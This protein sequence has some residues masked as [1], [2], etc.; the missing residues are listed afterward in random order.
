MIARNLPS[1]AAEIIS[2]PLIQYNQTQQSPFDLLRLALTAMER[3]KAIKRNQ[4]MTSYLGDEEDMIEVNF[5][6]ETLN[7]AAEIFYDCVERDPT[8]LDCMSWYVAVRTG[9]M[10]VGSGILI[11][12]GPCLAARPDYLLED[13]TNPDLRCRHSDYS[14]L[15]AACSEA[16]RELISWQ[17]RAPHPGQGYHYAIKSFLEWDEV[18]FLL[19][20]RP[21]INP[22]CFRKICLLH[23]SHAMAWASHDRSTDSLKILSSCH[24]EG[25]I[26]KNQLL[27]F[28]SVLVESDATNA[29]C[30]VMLACAL[31]PLGSKDIECKD[32]C[33]DKNCAQCKRLGSGRFNHKKLKRLQNKDDWWGKD[34][35]GWWENLYFFIPQADRFT[36]KDIDLIATTTERIQTY[37]RGRQHIST[38]SGNKIKR[39]EHNFTDVSWMWP[40]EPSEEDEEDAQSSDSESG[41]ESDISSIT[42]NQ[43]KNR[44]NKFLSLLPG[45]KVEDN[46]DAMVDA[47]F[48]NMDNE[49][50]ILASKV[51]VVCH[52][53]GTNHT[54]LEGAIKYLWKTGQSESGYSDSIK[55]LSFMVIQN[56]DIFSFI[57]DARKE[58]NLRRRG[59][60]A[61]HT[62]PFP[63]RFAAL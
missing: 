35:S 42:D 11:G 20:F 17:N 27:S 31:G 16:I 9:A 32:L 54:F 30:W 61:L 53:Y 7:K 4:R 14:N 48:D 47:L 62:D 8:N 10:I 21:L 15:R 34:P 22:G 59:N 52:L 56:L 36:K 3:K 45:G 37:C 6:I 19:S 26:T 1:Y 5:L 60:A 18:I 43:N 33:S 12:S 28:L 39:V 41:S 49:C 29:K 38:L 2:R 44:V 55:A 46:S 23:A 51:L 50:S 57:K 13:A 25:L 63:F 24:D 40:A 58:H